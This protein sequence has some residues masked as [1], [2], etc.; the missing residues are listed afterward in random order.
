MRTSALFKDTFRYDRELDE[1]NVVFTFS[2]ISSF[3]ELL[4]FPDYFLASCKID[5]TEYT[6]AKDTFNSWKHWEKIKNTKAL[7]P[8]LDPLFEEKEIMLKSLRF[9]AILEEANDETS[10]SHFQANKY[11]L[12]ES[13]VKGKTAKERNEVKK[14]KESALSRVEEDFAEDFQRILN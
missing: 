3:T 10:K 4:F 6:F 14:K 1:S 12:D 11:L 2:P 7:K 13:Y 8:Y 5:P 9:Q